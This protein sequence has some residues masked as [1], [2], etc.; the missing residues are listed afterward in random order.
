[1]ERNANY[2]LVG[3]VFTGL[4]VGLVVF[5]VWLAGSRF[6]RHKDAYDVV[7]PGPVHGVAAGG[8]VDF[9]GI[10]VGQVSRI[11]LDPRNAQYVVV[12]I[13]VTPDVPIKTDSTASL[14]P[15]GIT[16]V[17]F[18]LISAGSP[19]AKLL[20]DVASDETPRIVG[21]RDALA[22]LLA[23]G[24]SAVQNAAAALERLNLLMSRRNIAALS[25]TLSNIAAV[26]G[27]LKDHKEIIAKTEDAVTHA[28]TAIQ[29]FT[30]LETSSNE[31]VR[32]DAHRSLDKLNGALDAVTAAT[33]DLQATVDKLRGPTG[34]FAETGLP[35]MTSTL[36]SLQ[37]ATDHLDRVLDE[38]QSNPSGLIGKAPPKE[39]VLKP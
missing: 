5:V 37:T 13:E 27:A 39:V 15:L 24:G 30:E 34:A 4:L 29:K 20:R 23:G 21:K 25:E 6:H 31:L 36:R 38:V 14:E 9:N 12:R 17:N 11:G 35:Q 16:G 10:K 18:I 33:R 7:F 1:L 8:E 26:S 2:A 22:D 3:L 28:D 32:V 19:G